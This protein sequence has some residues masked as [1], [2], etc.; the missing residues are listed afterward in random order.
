MADRGAPWYYVARLSEDGT[1]DPIDLTRRVEQFDYTDR[2]G[3]MDKLQLTVDNKDLANFDDPVFETGASLRVAWG[4]GAST[5]PPRDMVI[6]KVT[7]GRALT[8][9][10]VGKA[11]AAMD[12]EKKRRCF[13]NVTRSDVARQI[14]REHGFVD[15]DIEDTPET[16]DEIAQGNLSD[17]QLLRKLAHLEGFEFYVDWQGLHWHRRR[18]G[19]A[20]VRD[21]VYF[22]DPR[23]GD[24]VDFDIENDVTRRP[25]KVTVKGR[26]PLA[27]A[28]VEASASNSEDKDRDVMQGVTATLDG[29]EAKLT[30]KKEVAH[31]TTV[32]SNVQSQED[33]E[34]AAKGKFRKSAQGA[35]KMS[36]EM[37]SDPTLVAKTVITLHGM[38]K[39]ISG[40]YYV[41]EV[42]HSLSAGSGYSMSVKTITDGFQSNSKGKGDNEDPGTAVTAAVADLEAAL[43]EDYR[44]EVEGESGQLTAD[45]GRIEAVSSRVR[46][47]I[48]ALATLGSLQGDALRSRAVALGSLLLKLASAANS[49]KMPATAKSAAAAASLMKRIAEGPAEVEAQGKKNNKT[50]NDSSVTA[51]NSV[52][53]DGNEVTTYVDTGGRT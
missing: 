47:M 34:R 11:A 32:A 49:A 33:G 21:Y 24:I 45:F 23:G 15:P 48:A 29:E 53:A 51:V 50:T 39:R 40:K 16:F 18:V 26:D 17:G 28:D 31:E 30:F 2:E 10:A 8:V 3:G 9:T 13:A 35:V 36:L 19:Q 46:Q 52:D 14:A 6:R 5:A 7:G 25:G 38:G 41:R 42:T 37:R 22:T 20:P 43:E 1:A 4:N 12:T 44:S 27:K